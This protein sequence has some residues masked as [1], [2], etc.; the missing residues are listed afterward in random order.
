MTTDIRKQIKEL[1]ARRKALIEQL[2][3]ERSR[4]KFRCAC[5]NSMHAIKDCDVIQTHWYSD[6]TYDGHWREGELHIICPTYPDRKNR[7][8][9]GHHGVPYENRRDYDYSAEQ[10]FS[11]L[12]KRLFKSVTDDYERDHRGWLNLD[13]FDENR[14]RFHLNIKG[15]DNGSVSHF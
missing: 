10:Q 8:M 5:C 2:S 1:D 4:K 3:M 14:A 6:G 7:V 15:V 13:Y 12:Y 9:F 11:A